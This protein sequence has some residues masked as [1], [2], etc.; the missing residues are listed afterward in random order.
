[1]MKNICIILILLFLA[2]SAGFAQGKFK[3]SISGTNQLTKLL[4]QAESNKLT[5]PSQAISDLDELIVKAKQ[6][7]ANGLLV[8]AYSLLGEINHN[9]GLTELAV[10]RYDQ[11]LSY[12]TSEKDATLT[13][14]L[15]NK[16]GYLLNQLN[17]P[18]AID[19][20]KECV[21]LTNQGVTFNKCYEGLGVAQLKSNNIAEAK[22]IF[23]TLELNQ[24]KDQPIDLSR[25]QAYQSQADLLVN[26]LSSAKTNYDN[27]RT[28]FK[29]GK[30]TESDYVVLDSTY[31]NYSKQT[32]DVDDEIEILKE[33]ID[34]NEDLPISQTQQQ[35]KLADAY[36]RKGDLVNASKSIN[37]ARTTAK[38]SKD[39]NLKAD[40]FKKSSEI[41]AKKGQYAQALEDYKSFESQQ[42]LII[43]KKESE[44][45][46]KIDLLENQKQIDIFE[47][48]YSSEQ[49]LDRSE[50][51]AS[52][53]QNYII[54][55]LLALL[56]TA[57][58]AAWWIFRS[59]K[60]Q[61]LANKQL[62]LKSLRGQMNPHFIFN[63]L[64][65]VNEFIAT[66][67]PRKANAYL[68]QFSKLMRSVLDVNKKDL[69]PI[70]EEIALTKNYL[71]LE[72]ARFNDKF[73]FTFEIDPQILDSDIE[74][75]PLLLQ[76]YI[77]N[78]IWHGLRY[79][80]YKGQL[81]VSANQSKNGIEILI[82]D[83]GI[84]R[85]KSQQNKTK[86]QKTHKSTG[87]VFEGL[88]SSNS[89]SWGR[90]KHY[91]S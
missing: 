84:G 12:A 18:Q 4:D 50:Q 13:T 85:K 2:S 38:N 46:K 23:R 25:V 51:R 91:G 58:F 49:K 70:S 3:K 82:S 89:S 53:F 8:Q 24:Y 76:P 62:E 64:N 16:K 75:P 22:E 77:E 83:N 36:I 37:E 88:L 71:E 67:N 40:V 52:S 19:V 90:S 73:D 33:N 5:N 72:H 31:L 74:V 17:K 26:D 27:A 10:K 21:K 45:Q 43:E 68:S 42:A 56:L 34:L 54:Y 9:T 32:E 6:A 1:M 20:F 41:F 11:A 69:I 30:G 87:L 61:N 59:L 14:G 28:N 7:N 39:V 79:L 48:I 65:S 29:R 86:H 63:A 78:S 80:D 47:N 35:V 60:A 81:D 44:L 55:L 57:L 66:Q 15:L